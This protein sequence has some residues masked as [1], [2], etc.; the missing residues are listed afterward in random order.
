MDHLDPRSPLVVDT[1]DLDRRPGSMLE[2]TRAVPAPDDLGT[3]VIGIGPAKPIAVRLRL[4]AVTEGVLVTG[5]AASIASGTCVRCLNPLSLEVRAA[6]QELYSYPDRAAHH[7]AAQQKAAQQKAPQQKAA[8]QGSQV[9][10]SGDTIGSH[11]ITGDLSWSDD[12]P[13]ADE[14]DREL[15]GDLLDLEPVLRDALV[16]VLPFKPVCRPDCPGLCAECGAHLA[17]DSGHHHD[18][19]DPRWA[20]LHRL[21]S[22]N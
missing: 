4:E 21:T 7:K 14:D 16:P 11:R 17:D 1:R 19:L 2:L 5:T 12:E 20:A 8:H 22:P 13:E 18:V 10:E 9:H 15:V 3:E 6:F